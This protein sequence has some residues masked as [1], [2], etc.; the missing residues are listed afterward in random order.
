MDMFF[1]ESVSCV[2]LCLSDEPVWFCIYV[3]EN[4]VLFTCLDQAP[5]KISCKLTG[6]PSL[7][8][9]F[10]FNLIELPGSTY[11]LYIKVTVWLITALWIHVSSYTIV[12]VKSVTSH[13]V[14]TSMKF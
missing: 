12:P 9:V 13:N 4:V 3:C 7:S 8:K 10:E 1:Y 5:G 11:P 2:C 14:K 6:S